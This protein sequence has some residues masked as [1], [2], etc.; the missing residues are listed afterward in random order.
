M[1]C[2]KKYKLPFTNIYMIKWNP[3]SITPIH[4]HPNVNCNFLVLSGT[5]QENIYN[6]LN[7]QGYY[8]INSKIVNKNQSSYINDEIGHHTIEN[9]LDKPSWSI[10]YYK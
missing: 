10:H 3:K 5:L 8:M 4:S 1:N 2:Y 9:L 6:N 7:K